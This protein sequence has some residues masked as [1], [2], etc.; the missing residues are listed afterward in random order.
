MCHFP[1]ILKNPSALSCQSFPLCPHSPPSLFPPFLSPPTL[2]LGVGFI[3]FACYFC[4]TSWRLFPPHYT[5]LFFSLRHSTHCLIPPSF[6]TL[7]PL[8]F[9]SLCTQGVTIPSQRRYVQ[10]YGHLIRN[11][12]LYCPKTMMIKAMRF[13]GIPAVASGTCGKLILCARV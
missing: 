12:F 7:L 1:R 10:Y 3:I 13:E 9:L 6:P 4:Y 11:S 5:F 2:H 8:T